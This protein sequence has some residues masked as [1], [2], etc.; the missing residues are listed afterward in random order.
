MGDTLAELLDLTYLRADIA[1]DDMKFTGTVMTRLINLAL[2]QISTEAECF[3]LNTSVTLPV[4]LNTSSYALT[5]FTRFHKARRVTNDLHTDLLSVGPN[6]IEEFLQRPGKPTAWTIEEGNLKLGPIADAAYT[7][8]FHYTMYE[9]PL[10]SSGD[11]PLLPA[12][13]S[14]FLAVRAASMA[15]IKNRDP[16]TVTALRDEFKDWKRRIADDMR[17]MKPLPHVSVRDR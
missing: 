5:G 3:W 1:S 17:Q 14:D 13:Y 15:A 6:E 8:V 7:Y 16:D 11:T 4:L 9:T 10:A 2:R 12:I